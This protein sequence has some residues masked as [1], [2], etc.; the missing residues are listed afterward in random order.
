[1]QKKKPIEQVQQIALKVADQLGYEFVDAA[2]EKE[3][4]GVY[5]RIYIDVEAGI[6]L[7]DCEKYHNAVQPLLEPFAY[8]FLE[9][10]SP[11]VDRPI[12]TARDAQRAIGMDV[13]IKTYKPINGAKLFS[14]K[15]MGLDEAGYHVFMAGEEVVFSQKDVA[16]ARQTPDMEGIEEVDLTAEGDA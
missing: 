8:D 15:F 6:G 2:F 10:C 12:K 5:L 9:V 7:N 16:L 1:M 14:G 4:P 13:E 3:A 11:G